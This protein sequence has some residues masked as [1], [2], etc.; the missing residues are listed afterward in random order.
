MAR[1]LIIN[2]DDFG[3]SHSTNTAVS[4]LLELGT[5]TSSTVMAPAPW[6]VEA[7]NFAKDHPGYAIGVHLTTTS[8]WG[9]Y[10]WGPVYSGETSS[11]R[12]KY[13]YMY[14]ESDEFER[15]AD[16]AQAE[17][18]LNA[19][20]DRLISLGLEPS[21]LDNHM[22]SMYGVA[23]GRTELLVSVLG[24]AA[25]RGL[26]FRIPSKF[27]DEQFGNKTLEINIPREAVD[28]VFGQINEMTRQ[29]RIA[30]VDY[31]LPFEWG[32]EQRVSFEAYR[33]YVY[34]TIA[35]FPDGITETY[36]H[37]AVESDELKSITSR[38]R[39]RV[40]E[41]ELFADPATKAFLDS[42]DITL[43]NYRDLVK[44]RGY[45]D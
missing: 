41:Y 18:E 34:D 28:A 25:K 45:A 4:R 44:L 21:H 39:D 3:M 35:A 24:I 40:W 5:I 26:P 8:E 11:L 19:Q 43:I 2:A 15:R 27:T 31:L 30:T 32:D 22:G 33:N 36:L 9:T 23:T 16:I 17:N 14:A 6:A 38:W 20:I 37:P 1:Y 29:Y 10:R 7:V 12:D 42:Q 13:G